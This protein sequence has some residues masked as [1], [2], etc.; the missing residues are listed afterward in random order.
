MK[1]ESAGDGDGDGKGIRGREPK[2]KRAGTGRRGR[3]NCGLAGWVGRRE[4]SQ[5]ERG[6]R[7]MVGRLFMEWSSKHVG[8][9]ARSA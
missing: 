9:H 2:R 4:N 6:S 3:E 8:S 5:T 1:S 7:G